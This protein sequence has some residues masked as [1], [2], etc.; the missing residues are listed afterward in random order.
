MKEQMF[1]ALKN[2]IISYVFVVSSQP[3][4]LKDLLKACSLY[5]QNLYISSID[6][7]FS[8]KVVRTYFVFSI[9]AFIFVAIFTSLAHR[10]FEELDFHLVM[11]LV[12]MITSAV[13]IF[14]NAFKEWLREEMTQR[15]IK[16]AWKNHFPYLPFEENLKLVAGLYDEA[17]KRD[18]PRQELEIY[19]LKNLSS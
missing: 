10:F 12:V 3:I 4:L 18:I 2:K 14:F 13:F 8:F 9:F 1:E 16:Q 17:I 19:I 15:R 5:E 6:L 11:I 7:G